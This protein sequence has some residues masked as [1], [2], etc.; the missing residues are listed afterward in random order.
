ML[1]EK[2]SGK[3]GRFFIIYKKI[4][5]GVDREFFYGIIAI[6]IQSQIVIIYVNQFEA[7]RMGKGYRY[8]RRTS[9]S[10]TTFLEGDSGG[11]Y[12]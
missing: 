12:T 6:E 11:K 2:F 3:I 8:P 4:S 7:R 9:C 1:K 5:N 10:T